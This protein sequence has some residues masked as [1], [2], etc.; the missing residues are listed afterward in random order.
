MQL[1]RE[2]TRASMPVVNPRLFVADEHG[3]D[4]LG[5]LSRRGGGCCNSRVRISRTCGTVAAG[6]FFSHRQT[7][8]AQE[9]QRQQRQRHVMMPAD[10]TAN[11]VMIQAGL[12][13]AVLQHLLNLVSSSV[14]PN[15]VLQR[16]LLRGP[17]QVV[18]DIRLAPI[19]LQMTNHNQPLFGSQ[20]LVLTGPHPAS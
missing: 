11:L 20:P 6:V 9:P 4:L 5:D 19:R 1:R 3:A 15:P 2:L 7:L 13:L 14:G 17:R 8:Q 18:T 10:V 12:A 16:H